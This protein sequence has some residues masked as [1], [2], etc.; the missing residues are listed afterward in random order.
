MLSLDNKEF[1]GLPRVDSPKFLTIAPHSAFRPPQD[2]SV[3]LFASAQCICYDLL[4]RTLT[5]AF[6]SKGI[7]IVE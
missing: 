6:A 1:I 3:N 7:S 5:F 2:I 4:D